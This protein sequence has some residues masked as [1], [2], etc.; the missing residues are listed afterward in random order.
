M[1]APDHAQTIPMGTVSSR[2]HLGG[3]RL[4]IGKAPSHYCKSGK[5]KYCDCGGKLSGAVGKKS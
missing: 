5:N 2:Y 4:G 1:K 3:R